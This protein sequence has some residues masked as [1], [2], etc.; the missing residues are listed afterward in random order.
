MKKNIKEGKRI[1]LKKKNGKDVDEDGKMRDTE[2]EKKV[3][4]ESLK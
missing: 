4:E 3:I 2:E 1:V